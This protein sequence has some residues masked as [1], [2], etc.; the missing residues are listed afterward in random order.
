MPGLPLTD[1]DAADIG[2]EFNC[3]R[4]SDQ[5]CCQQ[6]VA[7]LSSD[8]QLNPEESLALYCKPLE[9]YNIIQHRAIENP[10]YL[11]RCL[12]YKIRAKQ[13][14]RIQITIS[15][16]GINNEE[17]QEQN[18]FP[19]YVLFARPTSD[20]SI[21]GHSPIY[22]FSQACL[23]TSFNDSGNY[24]HA[25]AT[26]IIPDLETLIATQAYG[27]TFILVSCGTKKKKGR[28]GQNL[29]ENNSSENHVDYSS[30]QKFAGKCFWG[31]IPITLLNSS[32]ETCADLILG[33]I[34]ESPISICM[35]PG[36]LEPKFLEHD[37]CLSFCSRKADATV[38]Y[39]LQVKVSAVEAGAKD[40]LKSPYSSF[41][42]SDVPP[43]IL[44]RIVRLRVGNVLFNYKNTQMSEVTEDFACP[45]CLVRCGNF[46]GL[47]CH[48]TASHDLFHFEF[49][50]SED[51]QAVNVML[52]KDNRTA[53]FVEAE[54]DSSHRIF[55]YRSR[56]KKSRRTEILQVAH[57]QT[58]I[59]E[60]GS[61]EDTQAESGD[62]VQEENENASIDHSKKLNDSN[63]S[64]SEFLA[65][66]K[67]RKL[68]ANRADPRNRL[69]LQKRQFIHSHKAQPMTFEE[70]LSD[71]DSEDE[72]DDDIADL[73]DRRML[74]DFLD[75]TKDEK[76][77]MHMWNSFVR[78]QSILADSH[79]PWACEA[80]SQH[81][82][83]QLLQNSALL[84]QHFQHACLWTILDLQ[85]PRCMN[86][87]WRFFMIKL[88]NHSLLD[89][90][91]LD[92][93][94]TILDG[95]KNESS[96]PRK[97]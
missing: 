68:S 28:V 84:W 76:H 85:L 40:I 55:Y 12:L 13:K 20:V 63:H 44:L 37:S 67:S 64:P 32:L 86:R 43:S 74:D 8:E 82:G 80:F 36:Y 77:I 58:N 88:W 34:V 83:E 19:L 59:T 69:L 95:I 89:A 75:V 46:K 79:I 60:S 81:H 33:H 49:W 92:T 24:D 51:Y 62:D 54:V 42:Y 1:H 52:K 15:L 26:F 47:E 91:T 93:C 30:L 73:E 25:E 70:V 45:F 9:L 4:S 65:F 22:R 90:R 5:M 16:T 2:C 96:D 3:Q 71:N 29:G 6:F 11:Q 50:I 53:E 78:K 17:L 21:E 57:A 94:N 61:P 72:V 97:R 14:K 39:Q 7:Q 56:C 31:K 27:L 48:M 23:L 38:S 10:P 66:G 41:S 35:S 18:I 87:G